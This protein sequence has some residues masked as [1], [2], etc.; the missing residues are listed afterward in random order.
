MKRKKISPQ[1][2]YDENG[3]RSGVLLNIKDFEDL[4]EQ[5]ED[6][7]DLIAVYSRSKSEKTFSYEQV[8]D[9]IFAK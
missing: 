9:E 6:L 8:K 7:H 2:L 3:V 1:I 5:L 4:M